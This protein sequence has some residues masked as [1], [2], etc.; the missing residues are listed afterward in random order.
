MEYVNVVKLLLNVT[1][2]E[3]WFPRRSRSQGWKIQNG[4]PSRIA[5][6]STKTL[7]EARRLVRLAANPGVGDI[8]Y[9]FSKSNGFMGGEYDAKTP[10]HNAK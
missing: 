8:F 1:K 3:V 5:V 6:F 7:S 9:N 2:K 10:S 4:L